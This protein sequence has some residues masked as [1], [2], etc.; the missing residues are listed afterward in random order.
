MR[1]FGQAPTNFAVETGP[2]RVAKFLGLDRVEVR[3]RNLVRKD[4]FPWKIPPGSLY[5][6]GILALY[7]IVP[8]RHPTGRT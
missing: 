1:G 8:L 5:D 3:A 4:E 6:L 7:S 2:E